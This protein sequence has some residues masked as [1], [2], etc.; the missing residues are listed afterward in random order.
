MHYIH[1]ILIP[2]MVLALLPP[3]EYINASHFVELLHN[4]ISTKWQVCPIYLLYR[5]LWEQLH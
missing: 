1:T 5:S 3:R 4:I 2:A